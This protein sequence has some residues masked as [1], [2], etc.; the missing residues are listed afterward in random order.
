MNEESKNVFFKMLNKASKCDLLKSNE[1]LQVGK[2]RF[3]LVIIKYQKNKCTVHDKFD[4][5]IQ[6]EV[7]GNIFY[8]SG[9]LGKK[10]RYVEN[11]QVIMIE[12]NGTQFNFMKKIQQEWEMF[13]GYGLLSDNYYEWE[14][15]V[16]DCHHLD[17]DDDFLW[18]LGK[19]EKSHKSHN[20]ALLSVEEQLMGENHKK[21]SKNC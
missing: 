2:T 17:V 7:R 15:F 9:I 4:S 16:H 20:H 12:D 10:V 3:A 13:S 19:Y 11:N 5:E 14:R 1:S 18:G 21:E 6:L 8:S